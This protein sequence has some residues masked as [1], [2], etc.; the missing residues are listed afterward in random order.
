MIHHPYPSIYIHP[1][2]SIHLWSIYPYSSIYDPSIHIHPPMIHHPSMIHHP[3]PSII[4]LSISTHLWSIY[5]SMIH[6]SFYD[7]SI[8]IHPSMIHPPT[9]HQHSL[10][11]YSEQ[12]TP[13]IT[14]LLALLLLPVAKLGRTTRALQRWHKWIKWK[15]SPR[16]CHSR[17]GCIDHRTRP[18]RLRHWFQRRSSDARLFDAIESLE[19]IPSR[20]RD[21]RNGV[22]CY[23]CQWE[24]ASV[25]ILKKS[26]FWKRGNSLPSCGTAH[27]RYATKD[28]IINN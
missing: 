28:G 1:S 25:E 3:Y 27:S 5:P 6:P 11:L 8:H 18:R 10:F 24:S 13:D 14:E 17:W 15:H 4:H 2:I 12:N 22:R 7:P 20:W 26:S 19:R 23:Q 9:W 16:C 21:S